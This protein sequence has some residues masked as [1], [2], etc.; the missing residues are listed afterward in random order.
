M[1]V[2]DS[3]RKITTDKSQYTSFLGILAFSAFLLAPVVAVVAMAIGTRSRGP[4]FMPAVFAMFISYAILFVFFVT[5]RKNGMQRAAGAVSLVSCGVML[6]FLSSQTQLGEFWGWTGTGLI[7]MGMLLAMSL[8]VAQPTKRFAMPG[9]NLL[10]E[11]IKPPEVKKLLDAMASPAAFLKNEGGDEV[12]VA[13]N[14][15]MAAMLGK[16]SMQVSGKAFSSVIP[17]NETA[18]FF[19]F[20]G[21]EWAPNRTSRGNQTLFMLMP[22]IKQKEELPGPMDA[23]D[24][25]TGLFTPL[26]LKYRAN[27]D[28]EACRRYE[29]RLSVVLF[30]LSFDRL[31]IRPTDEA[32]RRAFAEFGKLV[33]VSLRA[34]DSGYR[35]RD[36]EVLIFLPDTPQGGSKIVVSRIYAGVR[37]LAGVECVELGQASIEDV[38][39]NYFGKEAGSIDQV[40]EDVYVEMGRAAGND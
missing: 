28:V 35:L 26:F 16:N 25:E 32:V 27:A 38:T 11:T 9:N 10:P 19:K 17:G 21:S 6:L 5:L 18:A 13:I 20:S 8:I 39:T 37:K 30:R 40:M 12:V 2:S 7:S 14:E 33:A 23:I 34:C 4:T 24:R 36:N 1:G 31:P 29:R 15:R 3:S 22:L